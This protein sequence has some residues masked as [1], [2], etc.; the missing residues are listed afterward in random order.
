MKRSVTA[1]CAGMLL[2]IIST[3][4]LFTPYG[5]RIEESLGLV[6][7]YKLRGPRKPPDTAVIINIDDN[8]SDKLGFSTHFSK[9]PRT[10]HA[11]LVDRLVVYG[12]RV[13]AF[14]IHFAE[15]RD[16]Q[17]DLVFAEAIRRAGNVIL[18]EE[19]LHS[20]TQYSYSANQLASIDME[21]LVPPAAP[22][23]D[24][25]LALAP[26]PLPKIPV[27]VNTTWRFQPSCGNIP[28]LP[29]VVFQVATLNQYEQ[30]YTLLLERVPRP[31]QSLPTTAE[32]VVATAGLVENMRAIREIFL[33]NRMLSNELVD[34]NHRVPPAERP[35]ET[36]QN[37]RALIAMYGGD[38]NGGIDFYG[39]PASQTTFTYHDILSSEEDPAGLI[40]DKIRGKVVFI[41]AARKTWSNQ[42]DGFY[43]VFSQPDGLDLS[44]VELA[45]TVFAN[46]S[47]NRL[48]HQPSTAT[49][50]V[51][52]FT[53][54][55][56]ACLI[57]FLLTPP[58]AGTL[59]LTAILVYLVGAH[60]AFSANATWTPLIIPLF[61]LP[62]A[63]F[64]GANLTN[65]LVAHRERRNI[66]T[67]LG[68]YLPDNVVAE[69]TKDI[70]FISKGDKKVYS[71]CL[72]TDAEHYT[73]LS[74]SMTPEDLSIHMKEYYR[75]VFKEVKDMD[76]LICNIIGDSM[77]ALW[78]SSEPDPQLRKK[79]CRAALQIAGAVR[80]FNAQHRTRPLPTRVGL[81]CGYLL[82]DNIGA[83]DHFEYAPVGDTVNT[84]SRIEGLNKRLATQI[85]ASEESLQGIT[86]IESR[87]VGLFLLSGKT[88]PVTIHELLAADEKT[89]KHRLYTELF[90]E[91]LA[92]FRAG[93]WAKAL[94]VF[95]YCLI[96]HAE[97]GPS[98]FYRQLSESFLLTPPSGNWQGIIQVEK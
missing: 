46:L 82:M 32:E 97:D 39:P 38:S 80:R 9:W 64:L 73:T 66:R 94:E 37:V 1:L 48:V 18:V 58:L 90:P 79:G 56:I 71:T 45:A 16:Q 52:I 61:V 76:G 77:L 30:L 83:E 8:S 92:H 63:A 68:Y 54:A 89:N 78:P 11:A 42:K 84:V 51:L 20:S 41:G 23:A 86:G 96:L 40:A 95:E 60:I 43:T 6:L 49:T 14:D 7:L 27:R 2:A 53:F 19:M 74:E 93:K 88:Q 91:A 4:F 47:E 44:G 65:Y 12:A 34:E 75:F 26:F 57:S 55:V 3:C 36:S 24:A 98:L 28:T 25:A 15:T 10:I 62:L 69:L 31:A 67:A 81:H 33:E 59:L 13:I 50:I 85:L 29:S 5:Q 17:Q 35:A 21:T 87:E 70:S 72:I 22:L